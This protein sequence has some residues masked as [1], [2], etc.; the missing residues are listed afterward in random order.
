[1]FDLVIRNHVCPPTTSLNTM[2]NDVNM[3]SGLIVILSTMNSSISKILS[4]TFHAKRN[5]EGSRAHNR[6]QS[7]IKKIQGPLYVVGIKLL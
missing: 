4:K 6:S 7:K 5:F 3:V 1:M 2:L